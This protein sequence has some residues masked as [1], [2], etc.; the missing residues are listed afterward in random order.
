MADKANKA[1]QHQFGITAAGSTAPATT[2]LALDQCTVRKIP[3]HVA[4]DQEMRGQLARISE[5]VVDG[6]YTVGGD[7]VW[8][9][10]P[11]ELTYVLPLIMGNT[12]ST[13]VITPGH[14]N[15]E[16]EFQFDRKVKVHTYTGMKTA[17][18]VFSSRPGQLMKLNWTIEGKT[19]TI[20][21][22]GTF[23]SLN[24]SMQRPF[25]HHGLTL[26][27]A[28]ETR[29]VNDFSITFDN[30]LDLE[31]LFNSQTR[32]ELPQGDQ[33]VRVSMQNPFTTDET[34]LYNIAIAGVAASAQWTSGGA[35]ILFEFPC[36]QAPTETPTADGKTTEMLQTINFDARTLDGDP[37]TS[38]VKVTL[39]ATA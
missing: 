4:A 3:T 7:C 32:T 38:V 33:I 36:L 16:F 17:R 19:E 27:V 15:T 23:P 11:A 6:P 10:R 8:S 39:D 26:T 14:I 13:G 18:A 35:S 1:W 30:V 22:A 34:E 28:G 20:G 31:R 25:I 12:F 21:D 29:K 24:L 9:P 5:G 2:R 37:I